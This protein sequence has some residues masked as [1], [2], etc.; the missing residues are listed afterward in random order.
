MSK[1]FLLVV[2][3]CFIFPPEVYFKDNLDYLKNILGGL[4]YLYVWVFDV[5]VYHI[6]AVSSEAGRGHPLS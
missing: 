5:I 6:H 2:F 4:F 1:I 3:V